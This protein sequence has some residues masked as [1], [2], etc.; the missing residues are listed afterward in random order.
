MPLLFSYGTLQDAAVQ[1]RTFGR[2]L[3]GLADALPFYEQDLVPI[4]DLEVR[5]ATGRTHHDHVV[6]TG[7]TRS[8]VTGTVLE[9]TDAELARADGYE[10]PLSYE[11][12]LAVLA[13]GRGAWVYRFV[14]PPVQGE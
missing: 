1:L 5:T 2:R 6:F 10:G 13:S 11:R 9:I 7:D 14:H 3:S 12:V 4:D 8:R